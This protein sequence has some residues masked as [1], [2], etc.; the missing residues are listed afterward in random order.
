MGMH[1]CLIKWLTGKAGKVIKTLSNW[2]L[3]NVD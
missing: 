3:S 1:L 2:A